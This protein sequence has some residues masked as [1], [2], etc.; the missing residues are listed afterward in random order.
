MKLSPNQIEILA[1][2]IVKELTAVDD[3]TADDPDML[4]EKIRKIIEDDLKV[5]DR[6]NDEVREIL[7]KY[8]DFMRAKGIPYHEM[9]KKVKTQIVKDRKIII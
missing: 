1:F 6:V 4:I 5:E 8:D 3:L 9:F 2:E 7:R